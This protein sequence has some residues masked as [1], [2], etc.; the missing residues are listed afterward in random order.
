MKRALLFAFVFAVS[1][2][3]R[4]WKPSEIEK[5]IHHQK[6][7]QLARDYVVSTF[8]LSVLDEPTFNPVRFNSSGVWGSFEARI[9]DLGD[10]RYEVQGWVQVDGIDRARVGWTVHLRYAMD[11]PEAWRY[12]R[13]GEVRESKPEFLG[14]KFG[15]YHSI[16]YEADYDPSYL[17]S[18]YRNGARR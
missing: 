2:Y 12:T 13:I 15:V 9:K 5:S 17:A 6:V 1:C 4:D 7:Y 16:G 8:N 18:I 14:W 3:G 11:D 10:D